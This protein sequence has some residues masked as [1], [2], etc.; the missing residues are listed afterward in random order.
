MSLYVYIHHV[1]EELMDQNGQVGILFPN[2][3]FS[4]ALYMEDCP[5]YLQFYV[6]WQER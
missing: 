5:L 3:E 6:I 1:P 2:A 4:N